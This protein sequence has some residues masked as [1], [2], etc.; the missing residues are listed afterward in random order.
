MGCAR[1]DGEM[2]LFLCAFT[3][4]LALELACPAAAR[5]EA[6]AATTS[7]S[8]EG[9]LRSA[10]PNSEAT[11][12]DDVLRRDRLGAIL[13]YHRVHIPRGHDHAAGRTRFV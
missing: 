11:N 10:V 13:E 1:H 9:S 4:G 12:D 8:S 6:P 3:F 5:G 7:T 2:K